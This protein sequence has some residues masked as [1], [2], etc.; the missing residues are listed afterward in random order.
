VFVSAQLNKVKRK[1]EGS[2]EV[3]SMKEHTASQKYITEPMQ[4]H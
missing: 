4:Q 3:L 2:I 1:N